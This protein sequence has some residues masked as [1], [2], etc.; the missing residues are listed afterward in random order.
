MKNSPKKMIAAGMM[1]WTALGLLGTANAASS[2]DR[3]FDGEVV[4]VVPGG[5]RVVLNVHD[6][7]TGAQKQMTVL[8][9]RETRFEGV[10]NL[11]ELSEGAPVRVEVKKTWYSQQWV[12]R[13]LTQDH[14][15]SAPSGK[16]PGQGPSPTEL[17]QLHD[18]ENR[19]AH[20]QM[21]DIEFET[22]RQVLEK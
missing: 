6:A 3:T 16:R 10:Q 14:P 15:A 9:G 5:H 18:M 20:G 7:E 8:T 11:S 21:G 1:V 12:A 4:R 22:K 19:S 17:A 13:R 2:A